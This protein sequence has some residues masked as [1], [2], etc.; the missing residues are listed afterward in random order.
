MKR[1]EGVTILLS[2][3]VFLNLVAE[4][5]PTTSDAVPLI[6]TTRLKEQTH[7]WWATTVS[8]VTILLS[9]TVFLNLVAETL[10]QVSDAIPLLGVTILLSQTVFSLL[11][12]HVLTR[13]SEA[14]PLIGTD[15]CVQYSNCLF[16]SI[17]LEL[18]GPQ[19]RHYRSRKKRPPP[20]YTGSA[21]ANSKMNL[22]QC[23]YY[24]HYY[25][26]P[27]HPHND[28]GTIRPRKP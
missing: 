15:D 16:L 6:D 26:F 9:L 20:S 13:T 8:G 23:F 27:S 7:T 10:P 25:F 21:A 19:S 22:K 14:V 3:T 17:E 12:A 2:L 24:C 4:S 5:M 28:I 11:V 1:D 18:D